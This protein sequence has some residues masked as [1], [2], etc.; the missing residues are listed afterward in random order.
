[1]SVAPDSS[2]DILSHALMP[3]AHPD[4]ARETAIALEPYGPEAVTALHVVEKGGG[5]PDKTP[6]EY[7]E[8]LAEES[9]EAVR[10]IFPDVGTHVT[11]SDD[12][13]QGIFDAAEEIDATAIV[14]RSRGGGR[15]MHFLSG[16]LSLKLVT[17]AE[18]PVI[19]LPRQNED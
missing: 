4:D 7:S 11:Y 5:A 17:R 14:Y 1:M 19:A 10:G 2:E 9:F 13:V 8:E 6:V 12:V 3:V 16:D 18:R 15:I